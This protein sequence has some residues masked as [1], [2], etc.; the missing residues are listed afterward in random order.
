MCASLHPS[1]HRSGG[2]AVALLD[3]PAAEPRFAKRGGDMA[4]ARSA[5]LNGSLGAEPPAGSRGRAPGEES[6]GPS[7]PQAESFLPIFIQKGGQKLR[8]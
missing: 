6:R 5:S 3:R 4:S 1:L 2:V 8:I 7:P